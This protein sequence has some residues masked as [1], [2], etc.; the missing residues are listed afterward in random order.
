M[1]TST[2]LSS[3]SPG[4][5]HHDHARGPS[6]TQR[7][8]PVP[9]VRP[10]AAGHGPVAALLAPRSS[11]PR[12]G[13]C[14]DARV[15]S[16]FGN[17]SLTF[18]ANIGTAYN[19]TVSCPA[20]THR[21]HHRRT[22]QDRR[23]GARRQRQSG[24]RRRPTATRPFRA[25]PGA[26]VP[27]RHD[28]AQR[29]GVSI[30]STSGVGT[31]PRLPVPADELQAAGQRAGRGQRPLQRGRHRGPDD[32]IFSYTVFD[33]GGTSAAP[34]TRSSHHPDPGPGPEP[35]DH[36]TAGPGLSDRQPVADSVRGSS[37][38]YPTP[39]IACPLTPSRVW[40]RPAG[41]Q[42]RVPVPTAPSEN[43]PVVYRYAQS[44]GST[45]APTSTQR[46]WDEHDTMTTTTPL[47]QPSRAVSGTGGLADCSDLGQTGLVAV[48]AVLGH[49]R[50]HR[51]HARGR[52]SSSPFPL[53]AKAAAE[54]Y[55][56]RAL[57]AGENAYVTAVNANPSLAQCNTS[58]N[59]AGTCS[60]HRLRAV[61]PGQ[62]F[63][64]ARRRRPGVLRLRQPP[65]DLRSHHPRPDQPV[66][67]GRRRRPRPQCHQPLPVRPRDINLAAEQRVPQQCLV[68]QLRVLQRDREL[69]ELQLQLEAQ[70]QHQRQPERQLRAGLLR[71]PRLPL[72]AG[73]HQRLGL[74]D[75]DGTVRTPSFGN[76][77]P[78]PPSLTGDHRR[79]QLP[80]RRRQ[81]RDVGSD[82]TARRQQR[83]RP[84]RHSQ[85][86][87]RA[88]VEHP[89]RATPNSAPSPART[90]ASTPAPPRS[91]SAPTSTASVR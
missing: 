25:L 39:A 53:Q 4:L 19:N 9:G 32:P 90:A 45:Y 79:P 46:R 59:N 70:L 26:D 76:S 49:R 5:D 68:V 37:A 83:R 89:R 41:G 3:C 54:V 8:R 80:V 82:P 35:A 52:P 56:H 29:P 1:I 86:L 88:P 64:R 20:G 14:P 16:R 22:G 87:L 66:R 85:Q 7:L 67:A 63:E 60:G 33:T 13:R 40:R 65:A 48:V 15:R 74:R 81:Q 77:A 73:L 51:G 23:R 47:P 12:R 50:A 31:G 17:F 55:A 21:R 38:S 61:E 28:R 34:R 57:E 6:S 30:C 10:G 71:A 78:P 84:L 42:A 2:L 62:R 36:R 58:T 24:H 75:G 43:R 18:Y 44:P 27:A 69:L 11:R 91:P 72:R